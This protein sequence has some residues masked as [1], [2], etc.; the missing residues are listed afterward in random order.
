MRRLVDANVIIRYLL[1]DIPAQAEKARDEINRGVFLGDG[2]LAEV[3]Y[4]LG[5][6]YAMP[7][8][9]ISPLLIELLDEVGSPNPAIGKRALEIYA[10]KP[11]LDFIDCLLAASKEIERDE[12]ITFDK[13]LIKYLTE[14]LH[15]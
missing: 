2:V 13:D 14:K 1:G 9:R 8:N 6:H 12:I 15:A 3:V 10:K 7:R 5:G 11:R 4:V